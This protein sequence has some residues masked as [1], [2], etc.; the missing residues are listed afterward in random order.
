MFSSCYLFHHVHTIVTIKSLQ[1][2]GIQ[3]FGKY[4]FMC[5]HNKLEA[6]RERRPPWPRQIIT[7][8]LP[9]AKILSLGGERQPPQKKIG[10]LPAPRSGYATNIRVLFC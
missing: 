2:N 9:T 1:L 6:L 10:S 3:V 4:G 8:I 5:N 7:T